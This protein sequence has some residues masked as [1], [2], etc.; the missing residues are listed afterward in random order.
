[1]FLSEHQEKKKNEN[2]VA[3]GYSPNHVTSAATREM[4]CPWVLANHTMSHVL[5]SLPVVVVGGG[6]DAVT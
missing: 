2:I 6:D 1:M 3:I 5:I 4:P